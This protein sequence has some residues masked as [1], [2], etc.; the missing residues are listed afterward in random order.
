MKEDPFA[1]FKTRQREAWKHFLPLEMFSTPV[2]AHTVSF[3]GVRAGE[4]VLDVGTGTGVVAITARRE[5]AKV[6]GLDLTPELLARARENAALA[7]L[8]DIA[9]KEGDA[10]AIPFPDGAFDVVVS[11]FAHM[12][13]PRPEVAIGEML[14]VL[15]PGGRIAFAT[16]PPELFVGRMFAL[17]AKYLPPPPDPKPAPPPQWGDPGIIQQRLGAATDVFFERGIMNFPA[18]SPQHYR[19]VIERTAGP[20]IQFVNA[21]RGDTAKLSTFRREIE[22]LAALYLRDNVVRQEYLLTRATKV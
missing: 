15:R 14:R 9:W 10:E 16:W 6:T 20:V 21:A 2:A 17:I 12:F 22:N 7:E 8:D 5:G 11:Q 13:A 19:D 1:E 18:L 3:A 4:R